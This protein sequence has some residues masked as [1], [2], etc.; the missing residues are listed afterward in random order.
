MCL[1]GVTEKLFEHVEGS[2]AQSLDTLNQRLQFAGL[3]DGGLAFVRLLGMFPGPVYRIRF[4]RA[5]GRGEAACL[6]ER[7]LISVAGL[8][9]LEF[10]SASGS[11]APR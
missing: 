1:E 6:R 3:T 2:G 7:D 11:A 9:I 5:S 8:K 10:S 4:V